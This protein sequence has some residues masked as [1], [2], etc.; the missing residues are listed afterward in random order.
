MAVDNNSD[1]YGYSLSIT[2]IVCYSDE[3]E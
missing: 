3:S 1:S 2:P